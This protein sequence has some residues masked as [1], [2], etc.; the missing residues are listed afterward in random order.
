MVIDGFRWLLDQWWLEPEGE[1][2]TKSTS[3]RWLLDQW[4]LELSPNLLTLP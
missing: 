4:W 3:F 1:T 2:D